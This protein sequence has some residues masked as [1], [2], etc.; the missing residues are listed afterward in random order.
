MLGGGGGGGEG[1]GLFPQTGSDLYPIYGHWSG[2][3][4][5]RVKNTYVHG[6]DRYSTFVEGRARQVGFG[7]NNHSPGLFPRPS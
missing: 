2:T 7:D 4:T 5:S 6:G 3:G 1:A